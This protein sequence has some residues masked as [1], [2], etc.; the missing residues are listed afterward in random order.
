M[1]NNNLNHWPIPDR[2]TT[3][4]PTINKEG[5]IT[6]RSHLAA[7]LR[8]DGVGWQDYS[9]QREIA[10]LNVEDSRL[11]TYRKLYE[12]LGLIYRK[13]N[14]IRLA[15]LGLSVRELTTLSSTEITSALSN[16]KKQAIVTLA[17]YQL[18]NP[19]ESDH[20]RLGESCDV[21][22]FLCIW[23]AM[24]S[25]DNKLHTEE[26]NRVMLRVMTMSQVDSAISKI[27]SVRQ[28]LASYKELDEAI[29]EEYLGASVCTDQPYARMAS[30]FSLA[31]WGG[32]VIRQQAGSDGFRYLV[33]DSIEIIS[34]IVKNP[35]P[36]Y[37]AKDIDD[38]FCYYSS[39]AEYESVVT[40]HVELHKKQCLGAYREQPILVDEHA[41]IEL[42]AAQGG[43]GHRQIYELV[44][45]GADALV[46]FAGGRI[47]VILTNEALYCAN[48]GE[49]IDTDGVDSFLTSHISKKRGPEIGR[50]GL[51]FKSV[52]GITSVPQVYSRSGSFGF[53]SKESASIIRVVVPSAIRFPTLR[54]GFPIDPKEAQKKDPLLSELMIWSDTVV[55][56][57]RNSTATA[58]LPEDIARFPAQFLLFCPQVGNVVL[59][60]RTNN[61]RRELS[62]RRQEAAID[63]RE[64]D[65]SSVW[66]VFETRYY[67]SGAA[68]QDAG[69]IAQRDSVPIIWAVPLG[70]KVT[71][72]TRS[73]GQ[74]WA[75]FPT[76][77]ATKLSGI[78]NAP[79]KTNEDRQN[80]LPGIF[81]NELI[82]A[83]ALLVAQNLK[84]LVDAD[85]PA[86]FLELLPG[87]LD[88]FSNWADD[89]LNRQVYEA[90]ADTP[91]LP[92]MTGRL[93]SP[94]EIELH[95]VGIPDEALE[96]WRSYPDHPV[97]WCHHSIETP[98]RRFRAERLLQLRQRKAAT[99]SRWLESLVSDRSPEASL[100][101]IKT[102]SKIVAECTPAVK[103]LVQHSR[104]LLD[105]K[106]ELTEAL[107][108]SIFIPPKGAILEQNVK[109]VHSYIAEREEARAALTVLGITELD[110]S[111]EL[112]AFL[113]NHEPENMSESDW[114]AF[115]S[116]V[117]HTNTDFAVDIIKKFCNDNPAALIKVRTISGTFRPLNQ[118]LLPGHIVPD[119]GSRDVQVTID[120]EFHKG[121]KPVLSE[122]GAVEGPRQNAGSTTESWYTPYLNQARDYYYQIIPKRGTRPDPN[123]LDF[124]KTKTIGPLLP[125][126]E[127]SEEGRVRFTSALLLASLEDRYW[128]L[129]HRTLPDQYPKVSFPS[130]SVWI[131]RHEGRFRTSLGIKL[132]F[133]CVGPDLRE[134][135]RVMPV[136]D[137]DDETGKLLDLPSSLKDLKPE[138][139]AQALKVS[140]ELDDLGYIARFYASACEVID[141]PDRIRCY[142]YNSIA[143]SAPDETIVSFDENIR[144]SLEALGKP[145]ILVSSKTQAETLVEKWGLLPVERFVKVTVR[146]ATNGNETPI[147]DRFLGLSSKLTEDQNLLRII[148]CSSLQKEITTTLG[149]QAEECKVVQEDDVIYFLDQL[150]NE[151]LLDELTSITGI[152]LTE[153]EREDILENRAFAEQR[154]RA[155][156]VLIKDTPAEKLLAAVGAENIR[157]RLPKGLVDAAQQKYPDFEKNDMRA[158]ELVLAV[159]GI[160][161]LR[162]F[163][164]ELRIAGLE[165]PYQWAGSNSARRFVKILGFPEEY[166]GFREGRRDEVL[167][168]DGPPNLPPLHNFQEK[169]V[170]NIRQLLRAEKDRRGLLSLPTGAGKTRIVVQSLIDAIKED[171]L[172]GPILWVAQSYEL[173]EQAVQSWSEVWRALGPQRQL[174]IN[175]FW[176]QNEADFYGRG[177]QVVIATIDKLQG[178]TDDPL[179]DWLSEPSCVVIDEAHGA[180]TPEYSRLLFWLGLER[181]RDIRPLIGLTATPFRGGEEGTTALVHRF[182]A[183]RLDFGVLSD[184]PYS[185]LQMMGVLSKVDHMPLP[186]ATVGDLSEVELAQL[187]KFARLPS[188]VAERIGTNVSRNE[189]LIESIKELD[190]EWPVLLFATSVDHANTIA[191]LLNSEGIRSA[192]ISAATEAGARQYYVE[193]FRNGE[194]RVLTNY[195]VLTAGFDAPATR[196]IYVARPVFSPGLY[197]QMIGRGLRGP[198][199]GGKERCLIVNV[200]DNFV[201]YGEKLAFTKFEYLWN[202]GS[203]GSLEM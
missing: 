165:P 141:A 35:P 182:F 23:K 125:L 60:D 170:K 194:L 65:S 52:L 193:Q 131:L 73:P 199:N 174:Q 169:I 183:N 113:T 17:K 19:A 11:R 105:Q 92:D 153:D 81:N 123:Y 99:I 59:E 101:A 89:R 66:K 48:E 55:K 139:W 94:A 45:N 140:N 107:P 14:R 49:P 98:T 31:G 62:V 164:E 104:I 57:P 97:D 111:S 88:E 178:C 10:G 34:S 56:L 136:I 84:Q 3:Q 39:W 171:D 83:A 116:L 69:E 181:R 175:R 155:R 25:L 87:R 79:W 102:A 96:A 152:S 117:D 21:L 26:L 58:W 70:G 72:E 185:E 134:W 41:R 177:T 156:R 138:H 85:D 7:F 142:Q 145:Y 74:F 129:R 112:Q 133:G 166:A 189:V 82:D 54:I 50:F 43:Y 53:N 118:A 188:S 38:W 161:A 9:L 157:M 187:A 197:Q 29:L 71:V 44:Q 149:S 106:G 8:L 147:G 162:I 200:N 90:V 100:A 24:L 191:A 186:G 78:I 40:E 126:S 37:A 120:R 159:Y 93:R 86:D 110:A 127:L 95:P 15:A 6:C 16:T 63:L 146:Y 46:D 154:E 32:L 115:W 36:Y 168:V 119:D 203:T 196:A 77:N 151:E 51:G 114:Q 137:C 144:P 135:S 176:A 109:L 148:P 33:D 61:L 163:R 184:D 192:A 180:V 1:D 76:N 150:N 158:A 132:M 124:N 103:S 2:D 108:G 12:R 173:C 80:L 27:R 172:A 67:T 128:L 130:P 28:I 122:L 201:Q 75:F 179:Y 47:E 160:E 198:L 64:G 18:R 30:I 42:T 4:F 195:G 13:S 167:E 143:S 121:H 20:R 202:S 5:R 190:K 91:S 68:R 22:P